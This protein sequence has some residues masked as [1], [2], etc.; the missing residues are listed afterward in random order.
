LDQ[1]SILHF[2]QVVCS[3]HYF[4]WG[5]DFESYPLSR[6]SIKRL[7]WTKNFVYVQPW[8]DSLESAPDSISHPGWITKVISWISSRFVWSSC[9]TIKVI[10]VVSAKR[11]KLYLQKKYPNC[12]V[13]GIQFYSKGFY[14]SAVSFAKDPQWILKA[15]SGMSQ[16][17]PLKIQLHNERLI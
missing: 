15:F 17:N 13:K 6:L 12:I 2:T 4:G 9:C 16:E 1:Q 7:S 5:V 3:K 8:K 10:Q 11:S 14:E